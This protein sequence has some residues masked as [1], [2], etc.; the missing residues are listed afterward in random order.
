LSGHV[1]EAWPEAPVEGWLETCATIHM[2][3]QIVGKVKL[4]RA[5]R[6]PHWWHIS[7]HLTARGLT[8]GPL[9]NGRDMFQIDFDFIDHR[10]VIATSDGRREDMKLASRPLPDFYEKFT[11]RLA[12]L[13]VHVRIWP[14]PVEVPEAIPFAEDTSHSVYRPEIAQRLWRILLLADSA[15]RDACG[16]FVGKLSPVHFFWGSFDLAV[17]RFSGRRAPEHPGGVPNLAD[18]VTREAYSHEVASAGFWPGTA[19][20]YERPAFY[21]YAYPEPPG[22]PAA[23]VSPAEAFYSSPLREFLLPYDEVRRLP[24]PCRAVRDFVETSYRATADLGRW[25]REEIER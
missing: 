4:A 19:G 15:L 9:P 6:L 18:W 8:T 13:G 21:A 14:V 22:F 16:D 7:L 17:T 3:T 20:G 5:P 1:T 23:R 24:D 12:A 25:P 10:L 2:W 11:A